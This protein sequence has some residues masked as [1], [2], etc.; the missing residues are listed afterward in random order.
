MLIFP[1]KNCCGWSTEKLDC[2]NQ[3]NAKRLQSLKHQTLDTAMETEEYR[4]T[5]VFEHTEILKDNSFIYFRGRVDTKLTLTLNRVGKESLQSKQA[6][7][8]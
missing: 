1:N 7:T 8:K 4:Q 2:R 5:M 3:D 6:E